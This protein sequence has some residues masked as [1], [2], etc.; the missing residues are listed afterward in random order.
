K[1]SAF[2][3]DR[4]L[5]FADSSDSEPLAHVSLP[6]FFS[7]AL[8]VRDIARY[9]WCGALCGTPRRCAAIS[10]FVSQGAKRKAARRPRPAAALHR[11]KRR[12][13]NADQHFLQ[14]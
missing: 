6:T 3:A 11:R 2:A 13:A 8:A 9:L 1:T 14:D 10:G 4:G 5:Y 7:R 12:A